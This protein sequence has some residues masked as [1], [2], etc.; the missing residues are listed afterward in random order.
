[1]SSPQPPSHGRHPPHSHPIPVS[2]AGGYHQSHPPQYSQY[3]PPP[4]PLPPMPTVSQMHSHHSY[5][6]SSSSSSTQY[7]SSCAA[8]SHPPTQVPLPMQS[9]HNNQYPPMY[10]QQQMPVSMEPS[11]A[12][13]RSPS[14][15]SLE[16]PAP[17]SRR[18]VSDSPDMNAAH[19]V[20][21]HNKNDMSTIEEKYEYFPRKEQTV[22]NKVITETAVKRKAAD[23]NK[24]LLSTEKA[25][26]VAMLTLK[27][28]SSSD[29]SSVDE[30]ASC[31]GTT[32]TTVAETISS[33]PL[34]YPHRYD[35]HT[36]VEDGVSSMSSIEP[37]RHYRPEDESSIPLV[38]SLPTVST[39]MAV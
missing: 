9:Y 36:T 22:Y 27:N 38:F 12:I 37:H 5:C 29:D 25:A 34:S 21:N 30:I 3:V 14:A 16:T 7:L 17:S 39:P 26:V 18:T 32:T 8:P 19:N 31:G 10:Q 15:S 20:R 33:G 2:M 35:D 23:K 6:N 4:P 11:R 28:N 24:S 1:M 13:S